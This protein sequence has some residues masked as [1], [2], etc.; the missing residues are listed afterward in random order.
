MI[1]NENFLK[2][3]GDV[4]LPETRRNEHR[5]SCLRVGFFF[6]LRKIAEYYELPQMLSK[7]FGEKNCG[8]L[9]DLALYSIVAENN[10]AQYYPD[11]T[12]NHPLVTQQMHVYSDSKLSNFFASVR[13]DQRIGSFK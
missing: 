1:P 2:Y 3:F 10:A 6:V 7:Y 13:D 4:E 8:L 9:L 5:N 11:Y 12:Y